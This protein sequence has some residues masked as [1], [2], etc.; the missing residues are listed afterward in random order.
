M[1]SL[2]SN[3]Q[4]L[5]AGAC[6]RST[7]P[8]SRWLYK[9]YYFPR[10]VTTKMRMEKVLH[11]AMVTWTCSCCNTW[12]P[13]MVSLSCYTTL[14]RFIIRCSLTNFA[15]LLSAVLS[16]SPAGFVV[17]LSLRKKFQTFHALTAPLSFRLLL[18]WCRHLVIIGDD[19]CVDGRLW[20][21]TPQPV[22]LNSQA[23][24]LW[25]SLVV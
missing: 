20:K 13:E 4:L 14:S 5:G 2:R 1:P 3:L 15:L 22:N 24:H 12:S 16:A 6:A 18:N 11:L 25:W 9:S 17:F 19:W 23:R 8:L 10:R 21:F 7:R